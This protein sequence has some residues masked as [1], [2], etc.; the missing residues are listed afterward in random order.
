MVRASA[1]WPFCHPPLRASA[2]LREKQ[3]RKQSSN[4]PP[5]TYLAPFGRRGP[6]S[7]WLLVLALIVVGAHGEPLPLPNASF[8]DDENAD[9]VPDGWT[10]R[11]GQGKAECRVVAE[12]AHHGTHSV[13]L[14]ALEPDTRAF[15]EAPR[16]PVTPGGQYVVTCWARSTGLTGGMPVV[17]I[18]RSAADGTWDNWSY[19]LRVPANRDGKLYRQVFQ[20]P[21]TTHFAAFRVWIEFCDGTAWFDAVAMEPYTP[22]VPAWTESF[23]DLALWQTT[24]VEMIRADGVTTLK[25]TPPSD[26]LA[27]LPRGHVQRR[28]PAAGEQARCL[29]VRVTCKRGLWALSCPESG[30][31]QFHTNKSGQF[32]YELPSAPPAVL[33][34]EVAG[35]GEV[36]LHELALLPEVPP[37]V[38]A[39]TLRSSRYVTPETELPGWHRPE[40]H[41]FVALSRPE[42]ARVK[43]KGQA[44]DAWLSAL[45][46]RATRLLDDP[47]DVPR[48]PSIY[49]M[50]Y[51]CPQHG[52]PLRWRASSPNEHLCP[53]GDHVVKGTELDR[54]WQINKVIRAHRA[55]RGTVQTL[56]K[57]YAFTGDE[58]LAARVRDVLMSYAQAFPHYPFH[59]GRGEITAEGN[60]MR[61]EY[62]PLGEAGWLAAMARGYDLVADS[63]AFSAADHTVIRHMLAEDVRVSLRYDEGL[64]NRQSHHNLAV[65]SVGLVLGDTFLIKRALGSYRYQLEHAVLG[66]G[67]WWECS[68]GYHVYAVSTL[69][70]VAETFERAGIPAVHDPKLRLAHDALLHFR[71]PDGTFPAVNDAHLGQKLRVADFELFHHL[72]RD[73]VHAGLLQALGKGRERSDAFLLYGDAVG[74][75][76]APARKST[77]FH[78]AG[79]GLLQ[80]GDTGNELCALL[81]YGQTVAG[82]GHMDKLNLVLS[83]HGRLLVPDI[84]T[85]SYFSPM[86]RFWDRQTLSHNT[87]VIDERSQKQERGRLLLFDGRSP[88]QLLQATADEAHPCVNQTRTLFATPDFVVD[89]FRVAEDRLDVELL[90]GPTNDIPHWTKLPWGGSTA[91]SLRR[92]LARFEKSRSAHTGTYAAMIAHS[93]DVDATWATEIVRLTGPNQSIR[94]GVIEVG[95]GKTY[96]L[97]GWVRTDEATGT[98]RLLC[99]WLGS[100]TRYLQDLGTET[101]AGSRPWHK[102]TARGTAPR[103]TLW[104]QILCVS[105]NNAGTAWF[106]DLVLVEVDTDGTA[107]QDNLLQPNPGFELVSETHRTI[108]YVL[109]AY[110]ELSTNQRTTPFTGTFGEDTDEPSFDGRN[111]YRTLSDVRSASTDG[112]WQATWAGE[113]ASLRL[114]MAGGTPTQVFTAEGQGAGAGRVPMVMAR[115]TTPNTV[116]A[117]VLDPFTEGPSVRSVRRFAAE[118]CAETEASGIEVLTDS[119]LWQ[120][121][122]SAAPGVRQ[123]GRVE[124]NGSAGA[125]CFAPDGQARSLYLANGTY[126][127]V[128]SSPAL[129]MRGPHTVTVTGQDDESKAV[130]VREELPVGQVLRGSSLILDS[131]YNESFAISQVTRLE[132][133]SRVELQGLPNLHLRPGM[134]G[135]VPT[136]GYLRR[137][138]EGLSEVWANAEVTVRLHDDGAR[139]QAYARYANGSVRPLRVSDEDADFTVLRMRP[140]FGPILVATGADAAARLADAEPPQLRALSVDG[141]PMP[142]AKHTTLAL[143]PRRLVLELGDGTGIDM[144][145][146]RVLVDGRPLAE[147]DVVCHPADAGAQRVTVTVCGPI[148]PFSAI[149]VRVHDTAFLRNELS[150]SLEAKPKVAVVRNAQASGGQVARILE[151][152]G[153]LSGTVSLAAGDY[154]VNVVS[155]AFSD[156]ANS[157]WIEVDGERCPDPIHVRTDAFGRSSRL[158][159]LP[160]DLSRVQVKTD[161]VH[162]FVLTLREAPGPLLDRIQFLRNGDVVHQVECEDLATG[163]ADE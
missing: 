78:Q 115:R 107:G 93:L 15:L 106:D 130:L 151:A 8:E 101:V 62:E 45:G 150:V 63:P 20:V 17:G 21:E 26:P 112:S 120:F 7:F 142:A 49:A 68:P 37:R 131:P 69:R 90:P 29:S 128:G 74:E 16:M 55:N 44:Y 33:R 137:V 11:V 64:S 46:S 97:S 98:T 149:T 158:H 155:R 77:T 163:T 51:N 43:T 161:G 116:F 50:L 31:I 119:G 96:E 10:W 141:R 146:C 88:I 36:E 52:V 19:C 53:A 73:P 32:L 110:G 25:Q 156:A 57:A 122:V 118:G 24:D 148:E 134:T 30:Y 48:E 4:K 66:D 126:V 154:E 14:T 3:E 85:R 12:E 127:G 136:F 100:G 157:L 152:D 111:S 27:L 35:N 138:R 95:P 153:V 109:H 140:A 162:T 65:A 70:E 145:S 102:V 38:I 1:E 41:P 6:R 121:A 40:R 159:T 132:A 34:I 160:P 56:G 91:Q 143:H 39:E 61:V 5:G 13:R 2:P 58:R 42:I 79:M 82:H 94:R 75:T 9:G 113:G 92:D 103:G 105:A 67:L 144:P 72:D 117:S 139:R 60:G 59:S 47:V 114:C 18:G 54:Q 83:A 135:T 124:L 87:V 108:D 81:D 86:Y 133:G 147:A 28:I 129:S 89:F 104:A 76:T 99:R 22:P 125:A 80:L 123:L 71:L 23:D 84:G